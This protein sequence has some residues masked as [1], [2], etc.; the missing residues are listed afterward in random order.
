VREVRKRWDRI[1]LGRTIGTVQVHIR[2]RLL[3]AI[4]LLLASG[5]SADDS[6]YSDDAGVDSATGDTGTQQPDATMGEPDSGPATDS[7]SATDSGPT[8]EDSGPSVGDSGQVD[9]SSGAEDSGAP[10]T[11]TPQDAGQDTGA[12]G[13][14]ASPDASP[15]ATT[16]AS[17]ADAG[18][19]DAATED[20]AAEDAAL[21]DAAT[22]AS[23]AATSAS[24]ASDAASSP[25]LI[26]AWNFDEGTGTS[27]ADLSGNGHAAVFVGGA[28]WGTGKEGTGLALDGSTGYADVGLTLINTT[29]SFSVVSWANLIVVNNWE[30]AASEDDVNGSL[31]GLKLRGDGSNQFDFDAETSDALSPGFVVAQSTTTATA[32]VWVH[33]AGVYDASGTGTMKLYVNGS[34]EA[35]SAVGQSLIGATGH[36]VIGRGLYNDGKGSFVNGTLDEVAVYGGALTDAQVAAIYTSQK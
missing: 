17:G 35:S 29:Q 23:D 30:V 7:G 27:S 26:G 14:D 9:S 10:D 18:T 22:D 2:Y 13:E 21:E 5:C 3:I 31:F 11:S 8:A 36:F 25:A 15:D 6:A 34:L 24:D 33:L 16:D 1:D 4:G 12:S 20:A 32:N 28:S 19:E